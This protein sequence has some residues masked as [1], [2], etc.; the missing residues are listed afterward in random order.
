[1][2]RTDRLYAIMI[3]LPLLIL[4]A[5]IVVAILSWIGDAYQMGVNSLFSANGIRWL[6]RNLVSNFINAPLS[7][8]LL[9]T[10]GISILV[11]SGI[12]EL[13]PKHMSLK[14]RRAFVQT[15]M[16]CA[17]YC[18]IIAL[19]SLPPH[20]VLR[21]VFGTLSS[22]PLTDG[23]HGML[24]ILILLA[25][26]TY[27]YFSGRLVSM[28]DFVSA[29]TSLLKKISPHFITMF[30]V[31]EFIGCLNYTNI[32]NAFCQFTNT[33]AHLQSI[34]IFIK[35]L[36]YWIPLFIMIILAYSPGRK[37]KSV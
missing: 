27:G 11:E 12:T 7:H 10:T 35:I 33:I 8:T 32:L 17:F 36:L 19:L 23:L 22:S 37:D 9:L 25:G 5:T 31:S 2:N 21:S 26:N 14:E 15:L 6:S 13:T 34:E 20:S 18:I 4:A 16:T 24:F 3:R 28:E 1:M 29:H 30:T